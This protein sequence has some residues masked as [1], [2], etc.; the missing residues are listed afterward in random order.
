MLLCQPCMPGILP[1]PD[2]A[3]E[4]NRRRCHGPRRTLAARGAIPMHWVRLHRQEG[5]AERHVVRDGIEASTSP[6]P[7][8][9]SVPGSVA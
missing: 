4:R 8:L 3:L 6:E 1:R 9:P 2:P 5:M 7:G